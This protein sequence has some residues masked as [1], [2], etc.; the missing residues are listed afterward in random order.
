MSRHP[1]MERA[2]T[3]EVRQAKGFRAAAA[4]LTGEILA[5]EYQ[6][7][8]EGAPRRSEAGKK[9]LVAPNRRLS[10]EP[11]PGRESEH[12]SIA[13]CRR[14]EAKGEGLTIPEDGTLE[15]IHPSVALRS[16][17]ADR[18]Q[19]VEDPNF[20]I[21]SV[22]LLAVGPEDR[23]AVA[24]IRYLPADAKRVST[25][26][27]PLRVLL[28]GLAH[29]AVVEANREALLAEIGER[30][31]RPVAEGPPALLL[32]ATPRYWELCR[33][34]EAQRGAA[35]IREMERLAKEIH[36]Q[37]G[38]PVHYLALR[39]SGEP[40]FDYGSGLPEF[41]EEPRLV[42]A[43]DANAGRVRPKAR[44]RPRKV[45]A[46]AEDALVEADPTRP[47]RSYALS[48]CYTAGDRI[49]HPTLGLGVV[50]G[51]AGPGK[52]RVLFD[53]KKSILVHDRD[54]SPS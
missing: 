10:A 19:G 46:Q 24:A 32:I 44:P 14:Q 21:G 34:R 51:A 50:Q 16:A 5:D 7:E 28:E 22:D 8:R 23:L 30:L 4:A 54:A 26:D 11:R 48:E 40:P 1:L 2:R 18:K 47:I 13:L 31:P 3:P 43:W 29:A 37:L 41:K 35:W 49:Q 33:K 6:A 27:T 15:A 17:P 45:Q 53:E 9:Y 36:E 52:I 12:A 38:M 42:L 39:V 25:G 20:G